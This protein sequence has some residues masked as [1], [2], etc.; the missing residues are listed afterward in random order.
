MGKAKDNLLDFIMNIPDDRL[1][2]PARGCPKTLWSNVNYR[3]DFQG[4]TSGDNPRYNL[5]IQVNNGA[6]I[7]SIKD[8]PPGT[9]AGP[10]FLPVGEVGD[11]AKMRAEFIATKIV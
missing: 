5:Q 3:L 9:V 4:I 6:V 11:P 8:L 7:T 2:Y 1:M 10:V